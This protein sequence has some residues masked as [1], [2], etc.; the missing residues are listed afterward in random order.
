MVVRQSRTP[1]PQRDSRTNS[2]DSQTRGRQKLKKMSGPIIVL[3]KLN[4]IYL[5]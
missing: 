2:K 3:S 4:Y 1:I 5:L